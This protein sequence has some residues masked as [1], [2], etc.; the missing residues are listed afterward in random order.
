MTRTGS[1]IWEIHNRT[2]KEVIG[3][4]LHIDPTKGYKQAKEQL[5]WNFGN[6]MKITTAYVNKALN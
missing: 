3:S 1:I 2:A 5:E 4:C 6:E